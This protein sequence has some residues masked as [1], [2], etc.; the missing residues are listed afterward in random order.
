MKKFNSRGLEKRFRKAASSVKRGG[1]AKHG[2]PVL[3]VTKAAHRPTKLPDFE[4]NLQGAS[5]TIG[6][7]MLAELYESV[8]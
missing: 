1:A 5:R 2:K 3:H 6:N 8:S 7:K 4:K